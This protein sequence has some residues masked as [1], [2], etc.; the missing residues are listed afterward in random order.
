MN[1]LVRRTRG[2]G[3]VG[4]PV[5][6]ERRRRV[7]RELLFTMARVGVPDDRRAVHA[8][9]EYVI[10]LLVPFQGKDRPFVL[11]ECAD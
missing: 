5:D 8:S 7:M 4:L 6:I 3:H 1:L 10:A 9:R 2:K 11:T